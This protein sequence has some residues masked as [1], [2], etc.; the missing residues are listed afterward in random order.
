M[1]TSPARRR[2]ARRVSSRASK[3]S[4]S[5]TVGHGPSGTVAKRRLLQEIGDRRGVRHSSHAPT[6]YS[7]HVMK[8]PAVPLRGQAANPAAVW[9]SEDG[10]S[11]TRTGD[12]LG[13]IQGA[14]R[15]NVP[16]LQGDFARGGQTS[17]PKNCSQFAG[18]HKSSGTWR[19]PRGKT[20]HGIETARLAG[21][22]GAPLPRQRYPTLPLPRGIQRSRRTAAG[23]RNS[24]SARAVRAFAGTPRFQTKRHSG[25]AAT[26]S[27]S[28]VVTDWVEVMIRCAQRDL[29]PPVRPRRRR[30]RPGRGPVPRVWLARGPH[31]S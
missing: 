9:D 25:S 30:S 22:E 1:L 23:Y 15:L 11:R 31:V 6:G 7:R 8:S 10:A 28:G 24:S 27:G 26:I 20:P 21:A 5:A 2:T 17:V 3:S 13:A 18:V 14:Q 12:L 29:R 16:V 4:E 19:R